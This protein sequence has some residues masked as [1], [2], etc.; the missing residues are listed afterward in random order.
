MFRTGFKRKYESF[1]LI[2][3][4][5]LDLITF[6]PVKGYACVRVSGRFH[7]LGKGQGWLD[8]GTSTAAAP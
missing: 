6:V 1:I 7:Q 3:S 5:S 8:V 2:T 4:L